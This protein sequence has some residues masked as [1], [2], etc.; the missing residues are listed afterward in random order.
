MA[1]VNRFSVNIV[2]KNWS[3]FREL[4]SRVNNF[5]P[6]WEQIIERWILHNADKFEE[7]SGAELAGITF[8]TDVEPV[9]WLGVTDEYSEQKRR[10]GFPNWLMVRTGELRQSLVDRNSFGWVEDI[11]PMAAEFGTILKKAEWNF[12]KRPV[13]FLDVQ[14][15]E[16]V[17]DMF[18]AWMNNDSPYVQFRA[19]DVQRMD[20]EFKAQFQGVTLPG[21]PAK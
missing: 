19:G 14:D 7:S 18:H 17:L 13:M 6:V 10:D 15:R 9:F 2:L 3:I 5:T 4:Q 12:L 11:E 16:M 1:V 20:S 21:L 8:D